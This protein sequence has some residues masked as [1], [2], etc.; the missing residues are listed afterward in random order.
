MQKDFEF[1]D[2][3]MF[4]HIV[5]LGKI[6]EPEARKNSDKNSSKSIIIDVLLMLLCENIDNRQYLESQTLSD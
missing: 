3:M 4:S 1:G 6:N 5:R 2:T